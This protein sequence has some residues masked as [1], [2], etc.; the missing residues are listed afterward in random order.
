MNEVKSFNNDNSNINFLELADQI[1]SYAKDLGCKYI[2]STSDR[3]L[4]FFNRL[5]PTQKKS[6]IQ[7]LQTF[8][9]ICQ[10][11]IASGNELKDSR[12]LLWYAMKELGLTFDSQLFESIKN[13]DTIEIYNKENIQIFRNFNFYQHSS[14]SIE[15]LFCRPWMDLFR[16]A[17][18]EKALLSL[19]IISNFYNKTVTNPIDCSG[20]GSQRIIEVSSPLKFEV[21]LHPKTMAPV[22]NKA[23]EPCGCISIERLDF[24][25][26][27]YTQEEENKLLD[28]YYNN[29]D[30]KPHLNLV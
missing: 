16:R 5:I 19:K 18:P 14:Y 7:S 8:V 1:E 10:K 15:D 27:H 25:G 17:D 20:Y 28:K 12:Q 29:N 23:K 13:T 11:S 6:V 3:R 22:L 4:L 9:T 21:D 2:R 30:H 26:P 24:A